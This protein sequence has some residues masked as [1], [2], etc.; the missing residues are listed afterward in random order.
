MK[1]QLVRPQWRMGLSGDWGCAKLWFSWLLSQFYAHFLFTYFQTEEKEEVHAAKWTSRFVVC[2]YRDYSHQAIFRLMFIILKSHWS[3]CL[4]YLKHVQS[5]PLDLPVDKYISNYKKKYFF[6]CSVF[7]PC[8]LNFMTM[9]KANK[10]TTR[11]NYFF[12]RATVIEELI[13]I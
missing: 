8:S 11:L 4:A 9:F 12:Y 13:I 5:T 2:L 6:S 10:V 1:D 3:I 7:F